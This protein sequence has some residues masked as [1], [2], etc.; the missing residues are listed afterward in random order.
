MADAG[1]VHPEAVGVSR[2]FSPASFVFNLDYPFPG[3]AIG[4][5]PIPCVV[6]AMDMS[7]I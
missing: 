2:G 1:W 4:T 5:L 6:C 3:R 7:G